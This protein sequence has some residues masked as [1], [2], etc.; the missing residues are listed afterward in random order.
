MKKLVVLS[1]FAATYL[2]VM[3]NALAA[4]CTDYPYGVGGSPEII[5]SNKFKFLYTSSV[6]VNIDDISVINDAREEA[7]LEAKAGIARYLE[8]ILKSET[9]INK[10]VDESVLIKGDSKSAARVEA[11]KTLKTLS[12]STQRL[13]KGVA[14]LGDCY[15]K[16]TELRVTVGI[17][18]ETIMNAGTISNEM[19]NTS[20][21]ASNGIG[22]TSGS[23][24]QTGQLKASEGFS[25]T[26]RL[27]NF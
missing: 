7:T 24:T 10:I 4:S 1:C 14:V 17:K 6:A 11:K 8:E 2:A 13:L 12:G 15:T 3:G 9:E 21:S 26:E 18:P 20:G 23:T 16:G 27:R 22:A 25:N 5:D 19:A